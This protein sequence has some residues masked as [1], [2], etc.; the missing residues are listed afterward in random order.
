MMLEINGLGHDYGAI[1]IALA[2]PQPS[3]EPCIYIYIYEMSSKQNGHF[4]TLGFVF[5]LFRQMLQDTEKSTLN[6]GIV[7]NRKM[8]TLS[9]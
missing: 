4:A 7:V 2:K 6:L 3:P 9:Y 1:A 8:Q 5:P